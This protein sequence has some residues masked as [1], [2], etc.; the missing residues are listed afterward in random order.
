M[1]FYNSYVVGLGFGSSPIAT[2]RPSQPTFLQK[3]PVLVGV[4]PNV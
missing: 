4:L 1:G 3:Q 2:P